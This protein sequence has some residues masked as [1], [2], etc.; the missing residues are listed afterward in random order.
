MAI[1]T[2]ITNNLLID[3]AVNSRQ[4]SRLSGSSHFQRPTLLLPSTTTP[5]V[6]LAKGRAP[7]GPLRHPPGGQV[8]SDLHGHSARAG[9][10]LGR[11]LRQVLLSDS[12]QDHW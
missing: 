4:G 9:H 12:P 7:A 3:F 1:P 6:E 5:G 11:L 2:V 10:H 8:Y